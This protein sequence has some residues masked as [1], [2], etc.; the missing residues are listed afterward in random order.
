MSKTLLVGATGFLGGA[1]A[2][3]L[4]IEDT[5]FL[6]R[7]KDIIEAS[8]KLHKNLL[9]FN[10]TRQVPDENIIVSDLANFDI[11]IIQAQSITKVINA[12]GN[13]SF[14]NNDIIWKTNVDDTLKFAKVIKE[15]CLQLEEY[16]HLG[17]AFEYSDKTLYTK[18]KREQVRLL[19]E[20]D[21]PLTVLRPAIIVGHTTLGCQPSS[22]IFWILEAAAAT[23]AFDLLEGKIVDVT[24][25]DEVA[26]IIAKDEYISFEDQYITSG[27]NANTIDS[28]LA[29]YKSFKDVEPLSKDLY[30]DV[31]LGLA[32]YGYFINENKNF[33][34][35]GKF[36]QTKTPV[37]DYID[38]MIES[39]SDLDIIQMKNFDF[40]AHNE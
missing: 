18:S 24:A 33:S 36:V 4:E 30:K 21:L 11:D 17:T 31:K 34:K 8:A 29:T 28:I 25:V 32:L 16:V 7:G 23:N 2:T 40:G 14:S 38:V 1:I 13:T 10:D 19:K 39:L 35:M 27:A 9:K 5:L 3:E 22:S 26:S 12:G 37:N 15:K 20:L 6:V